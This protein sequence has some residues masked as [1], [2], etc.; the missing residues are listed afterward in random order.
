MKSKRKPA[1][2]CSVHDRCLALLTRRFQSLSVLKR[3]PSDGETIG[4]LDD[5]R[6]WGFAVERRTP[7]TVNGIACGETVEFRRAA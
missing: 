4:G 6:W 3:T 2:W 7:I 1:E 5:L